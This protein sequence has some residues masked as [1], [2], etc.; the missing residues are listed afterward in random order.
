MRFFTPLGFDLQR[1]P[2]HE[3]IE[4]QFIKVCQCIT[5]VCIIEAL[6]IDIDF[7]FQS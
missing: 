4:N 5:V 6:G 3:V 2:D 7:D 1:D